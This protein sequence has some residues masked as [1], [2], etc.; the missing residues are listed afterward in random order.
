[1]L[2]NVLHFSNNILPEAILFDYKIN[3]F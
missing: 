3:L 1:M 2:R